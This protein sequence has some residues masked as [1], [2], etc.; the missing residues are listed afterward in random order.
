MT[1]VRPEPEEPAPFSDIHVGDVVYIGATRNWC[2][3][4]GEKVTK[5]QKRAFWTGRDKWDRWGAPLNKVKGY[6]Y[7]VSHYESRWNGKPAYYQ[8]V[9]HGADGQEFVVSRS[10]RA[11]TR[12]AREVLQLHRAARKLGQSHPVRIKHS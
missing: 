2:S 5:V 8:A 1:P 12:L 4:G 3:G 10:A 6:V 11:D 7:Y 9:H